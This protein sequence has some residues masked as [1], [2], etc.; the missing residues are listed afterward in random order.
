MDRTCITEFPIPALLP[1][2][3]IAN[4]LFYIFHSLPQNAILHIEVSMLYTLY[5]SL[6]CFRPLFQPFFYISDSILSARKV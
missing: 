6:G 2:Y 3:R 4:A 5:L 1:T